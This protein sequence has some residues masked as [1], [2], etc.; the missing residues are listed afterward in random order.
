MGQASEFKEDKKKLDSVFSSESP[1]P[2]GNSS[3]SFAVLQDTIIDASL[4]QQKA[5]GVDDYNQ[6]NHHNDADQ[7]HPKAEIQC[8]A[9]QIANAKKNSPLSNASCPNP[10][11]HS[12]SF[13]H[14]TFDAY[15]GETDA[16]L[17]LE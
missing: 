7:F 9:N 1:D 11:I 8:V 10:P 12:R 3:N 14:V 6:L 13:S 17:R 4:S 15:G 2:I 5:Y 16:N